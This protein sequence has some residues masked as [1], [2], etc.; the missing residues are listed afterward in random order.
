MAGTSAY[1]KP[2]SVEVYDGEVVLRTS[3]GPFS[4]SLTPQAAAKT[5]EALAEAAKLALEYQASHAEVVRD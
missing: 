2:L 1:E 3:E 4:A 5:A